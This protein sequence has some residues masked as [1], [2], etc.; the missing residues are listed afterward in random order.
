MNQYGEMARRHWARWLPGRFAAIE[1]P[2]AFFTDLGD[3]AE[4]RI[5]ALA[6]ELAG[7]DP[8]GEGYL[9]KAGRLGE[10]RHRAEQIVLDE[11]IL[12]PPEP[13]TEP[14]QPASSVASGPA[15]RTTWPRRARSAGSAPTSPRCR[16]LRTAQREARPATPAEQEVLAR[17]SGWGAVPEVFDDRRAEFAW[18]RE[19][20]AGLLSPAELAAARRNTLN[21]HYTDAALVQAM[22]RAVRALGFERGRVLEPGCGSGNFIAFAPG[23]A[24][25]TGIELDPVTAGIAGL[26]YP[27]AEIR[28]ESFADSRDADGS[29]DLA[30]GNVPFGNMVLHDRRHNPA[31]HSIHNHFI[32]K[33]LHLVRPGRPGG[34]AHLPVHDGR[35]Q[36]GRAPGD[37]LAGRPGRR[38]PAA[39]RRPPA[40][41]GHRRGHRPARAAPPRTRPAARPD[42]LG[43]DTARRTGRRPGAGQRVLPRT[44][45]TRCSARWEPSTAPTGPTT[46]WS[47]HPA[48]R[49][50]RSPPPWTR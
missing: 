10:A 39:R 21:A 50:P 24:Q 25:V 34:G 44:T 43:E 7:D 16:S 13:G 12:L 48:T 11:M 45:R 42:R 41:R 19:Q 27:D 33:A 6:W 4:Q 8:P 31:G 49:S 29:Y 1:D 46:W 36:P 26:L 9:A 2:E 30:I 17:W 3:E 28:A 37:R 47:A 35:P 5:T 32:V 38:D 18:A 22:W 15:A 23:G 14:G 40:G 20:L